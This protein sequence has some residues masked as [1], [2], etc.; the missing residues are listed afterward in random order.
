MLG[1][2]VDVIFWAS[3]NIHV[4]IDAGNQTDT[5]TFL[6]E[7][8]IVDAEATNGVEIDCDRSDL[9]IAQMEGLW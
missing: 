3:G 8:F 9:D 2:I 6:L 1:A 7:T 5:V 4:D